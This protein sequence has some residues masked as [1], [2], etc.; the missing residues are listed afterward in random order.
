MN[1]SSRH[2]NSN[3]AHSF[4]FHLPYQCYEKYQFVEDGFSLPQVI[5][6]TFNLNLE[7]C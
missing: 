2:S 7:H 3:F 6:Q 5:I 4:D 1:I